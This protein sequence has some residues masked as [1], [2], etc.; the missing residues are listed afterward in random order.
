MLEFFRSSDFSFNR[1]LIVFFLP[2]ILGGLVFG[3]F[4]PNVLF[5]L[6]LLVIA[7]GLFK[8]WPRGGMSG[9]H[10]GVRG[11]ATLALLT[12]GISMIAGHGLA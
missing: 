5:F 12:V 7:V 1:D 4:F 8:F 10:L 3:Y 2:L 6:L 9:A 11:C